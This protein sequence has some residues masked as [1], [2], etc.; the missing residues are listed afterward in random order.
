MEFTKEQ[1]KFLGMFAT[2]SNPDGQSERISTFVRGN[3]LKVLESMSDLICIVLSK[4]VG[5]NT[6]YIEAFRSRELTTEE[7]KQVTLYKI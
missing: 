7:L 1:V 5:D 6:F 3:V 2:D 4:E